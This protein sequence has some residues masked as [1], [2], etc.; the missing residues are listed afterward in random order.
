MATMA[1]S[2]RIGFIGCGWATRVLHLPALQRL[3]NIEIVAA[4]D[5]NHERLHH[6]ANRYHIPRRYTDYRKLVEDADIDVVAVCVPPHLNAEMAIAA[7]EAGKHLFIEK[8]LAL[9]VGECDQIL[10]RAARSKSKSMVGH[11][12]RWHPLVRQARNLLGAGTLGTLELARTVLTKP[13]ASNIWHYLNPPNSPLLAEFAVHHFDLWRFLFEGE[14]E[15]IFAMCR[16][17]AAGEAVTVSAR[18]NT[19]MLVNGT[20]CDF[21]PNMNDVEV[22]GSRARLRLSCYQWNSLEVRAASGTGGGPLQQ[23]AKLFASLPQL[24]CARGMFLSYAAEWQHFIDCI[25]NDQP[26]E[27]TL[28]IGRQAVRVAAAAME[29]A[30]LRQPVRLALS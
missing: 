11:N 13:S 28:E 10:H 8:P 6:L 16:S 7:L 21:A 22:Y 25:R 1:K 30:A 3:R 29:S 26:V 2:P 18:L 4:A 23:V 17:M 24:E 14:I 15:E 9:S 27:A 20:F 19:G 12:Q 5:I